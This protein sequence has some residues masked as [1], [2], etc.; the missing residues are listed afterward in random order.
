M[1]LAER[2]AALAAGVDQGTYQP[3]LFSLADSWDRRKVEEL[4]A[5]GQVR[6]VH[7]RYVEQLTELCATRSPKQRLRGAALDEV[8]RAA[9]GDGPPEERGTWVHYPWSGRLVHVLGEAEYRELRFSRNR[10]KITPD[11]QARLRDKRIG[12]VGLSVGQASAVTLALEGVGGMLRL[13]DFDELAL[14]NMNR[15]RAGVHEIGL[16]KC[17]IAAR[18]IAEIDPY[19]RVEV[20]RTG[21]TEENVEAFLNEGG[22]LDLVIEECDDLYTKV[23]LRER[24]RAHGIPVLMETNDRGMLDVERFDQEPDRP[25]LHSLLRGLSAADL[26]GLTQAQKV[27]IVLRIIGPDAL[28]GRLGASLLEVEET[29]TSWPQLASGTMLGGAVSTDAARRVL[30]GE[31]TRSGRYFVDLDALVKDGREAEVLVDAALEEA[32]VRKPLP[33]PEAPP[34]ARPADKRTVTREDVR[35]LVGFGVLAPSGGNAQPWRFVAKGGRVRCK[36]SPDGGRSLNDFQ[37]TAS[38]V[39]LGAAVENMVLAAPAMGL[40][41]EVV[42]APDANDPRAACDVVFR[43]DDSSYAVDPLCAVIGAR[44]TNRKPGTGAALSE[45]AAA[46]LAEAAEVRG[47]KLL[48][49]TDRS[50]IAEIGEILGQADRMLFLSR[51]HNEEM[52]AE[53]RWTEEEALRTRDGLDV[54][55][56]DVPPSALAAVRLATTWKA[57]EFAAKMGGGGALAKSARQLVVSSSAMALVVFPG[58]SSR[59][60]FEGGRALERVWLDATAQGIALQPW[61]AMLYLFARLERGGAKGL[62]P[63]VREQLGELRQ[64]FLRVFDVP[65]GHAEILLFRLSK[66]EPP[67]ARSLRKPVEDVL[68]FV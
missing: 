39:A 35:R 56:L 24:A 57:V 18:A 3:A 23:F 37:N 38:F 17:V 44:S 2:L 45:Y 41:A 11:E 6:E 15:L 46:R 29:T 47:G 54:L 33:A 32:L 20:I 65:A 48:L 58:T 10:Y 50:A 9:L 36:V 14:S 66:A 5:G 25:V 16:H 61:S 31:L 1:K 19:V 55:T 63:K 64:R 28:K 27:A 21:I 12:V 59:S 22:K 52:G 62:E 51:K 68:T 7:D 26:K 49:V 60:Y 67:T 43:V 8:V 4:V 34:L 13:A 40:S 42:D 53:L 30:L